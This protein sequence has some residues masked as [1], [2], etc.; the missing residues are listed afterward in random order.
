MAAVC[1]GAAALVYANTL[2]H[3]YA[4]D[5]YPTIYGN[6]LT[7]AG[8]HGIPTLLHTAYW[9]GL[10]GMS[11]WLY[12][13]LSMVM[14]AMEWELA[15]NTPALGHWVN[16]L[17]Y[18]LS[19]YLLFRFL[20]RLFDTGSV[21]I[22]FAIALLWIAHPVHTEVVA[23]IKSRDELLAFLFSIL[24]L[25]E[26]VSYA[27]EPRGRHLILTGLYLF[28][29]LLAKESSITLVVIFPMTLFVFTHARAPRISRA[30][31]PIGLTALLYLAIRGM[32]L[33]SQTGD[34]GISLIDNSLMAAPDL[35]HRLA[36]AFAI[37]GR[38]IGLLLFP[39]RLSSDYSFR[40]IPVVGLDD[41]MACASAAL[42]LTLGV[43]GVMR[44]MKR[45]PVGYGIL[46]YLIG[47]AL[48]GNVFF[49]THSTMAERFLYA[50]SLGFCIAFVLIVARVCGLDSR[51]SDATVDATTRRREWAFATTIG[52]VLV[53][54]AVRSAVRNPEWKNDT[55]LFAADSRHSPNSARIHFL[56]GNHLLQELKL[57]RVRS[58]RQRAYYAIALGEFHQAIAL[59]PAY[60]EPHLG[61]GDAYAFGGDLAAA[62]DWYRS[63]VA[64]NS[65]FAPGYSGLGNTY[66]Q[67]QQYDSAAVYLKKALVMEPTNASIARSLS[68]AYR[69]GGDTTLARTYLQ[70]AATLDRARGK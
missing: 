12:R 66:A 45:D 39:T 67:V 1:A 6:R 22:P 13:P 28:L 35:A 68:L 70:K 29:A 56:Y 37:G 17:L 50:P 69:R 57:G 55:T 27:R 54:A 9:Y 30:M 26:G 52:L 2:H 21:A 64:R 65:G 20:C 8:V 38:Y 23:N 31:L 61:I 5:D 11:N 25:S 14:F 59:Y 47:I 48:V 33:T 42:Y 41:P 58:D 32:V 51:P 49:L 4:M 16:V 46:F 15:P 44:V 24:A 43:F 19:A 36:T 62:I 34:G 7:M 53:V 63:M 10:D 3:E 40:Q 18:A 60:A